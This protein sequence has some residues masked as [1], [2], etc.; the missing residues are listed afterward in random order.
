[1]PTTSLLK[2][3]LAILLLLCLADWPYGYYQFVRFVAMVGFAYLA[4][5]AS[6]KKQRG[7]QVYHRK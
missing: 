5:D 6:Q 1:M 2:I 7:F 4:Y 3:F